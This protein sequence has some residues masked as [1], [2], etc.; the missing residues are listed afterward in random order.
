M[1]IQLVEPGQVNTSMTELF[2]ERPRWSAPTASTFVSSA[3]RKLG[4]S[5]RTCGYWAHSFQNW[6]LVQWLLPEWVLQH[7]TAKVG[8]KQY[9]HAI[10]KTKKT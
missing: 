8:K 2:E 10:D 1:D 4:F 9:D 3:I 7:S 5:A 6:L